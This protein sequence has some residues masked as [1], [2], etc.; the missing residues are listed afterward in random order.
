MKKNIFLIL[1]IIALLLSC[2]KDDNND[3]DNQDFQNFQSQQCSTAIG[4]MGLYW[5]YANGL[6]VSLTQIP[7][8]K[9]PGTYFIH[10]AYPQLGFQMPRGV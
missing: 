1:L 2:N 7:T 4:L 5:D 10:S 6:P 8:I 9:N 3:N